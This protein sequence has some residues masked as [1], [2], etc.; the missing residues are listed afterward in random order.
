M[1][2]RWKRYVLCCSRLCLCV[3]HHNGYDDMGGNVEVSVRM[4]PLWLL[5]GAE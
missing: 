5:G 4:R 3:Y 1:R 2:V